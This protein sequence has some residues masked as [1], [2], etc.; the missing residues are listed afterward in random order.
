[1]L[2]AAALLITLSQ[3]PQ[4]LTDYEKQFLAAEDVV[5]VTDGSSSREQIFSQGKYK[6][7]LSTEE[8]L[9]AVGRVE[10]ADR[11]ETGQLRARLLTFGSLVSVL[12]GV[13][14]T[15][16]AGTGSQQ[17]QPGPEEMGPLVIGASV[18]AVLFASAIVVYPSPPDPVEMRRLADEHNQAL[19]LKLSLSGRF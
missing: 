13:V 3:S 11:R 8:F 6:Q 14:A 2:A 7:P 16:M 9:R 10:E 17:H 18:G 15:A 12:V 19:R 1:M 4:P 5:A